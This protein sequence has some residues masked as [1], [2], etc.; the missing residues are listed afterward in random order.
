MCRCF[1][2]NKNKEKRTNN[3]TQLNRRIVHL[4]LTKIKKKELIISKKRDFTQI[5]IPQVRFWKSLTFNSKKTR[6]YANTH[7]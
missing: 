3:H 7:L 1:F 5:H 2:S 4:S 6:F